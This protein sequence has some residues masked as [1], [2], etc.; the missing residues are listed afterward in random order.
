MSKN[1]DPQVYELAARVLAGAPQVWIDSLAMRLQKE[2]D[3]SLEEY[4]EWCIEQRS[5]RGLSD[6]EKARI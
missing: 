6:N 4:G 3:D 1:I 2:C 5:L